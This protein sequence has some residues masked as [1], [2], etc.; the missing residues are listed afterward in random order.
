VFTESLSQRVAVSA[1][2]HSEPL[3]IKA[4]LEVKYRPFIRWFQQRY[5]AR[6]PLDTIQTLDGIAIVI[7]IMAFE[8]RWL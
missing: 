3:V 6:V 8:Q 4:S 2:K 7:L 1:K 5:S